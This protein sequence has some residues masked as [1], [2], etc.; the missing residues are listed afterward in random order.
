MNTDPKLL[1]ICHGNVGRSQ[2]A[3]GFYNQMTDSNDASSAGID[4]ST[5]AL[6]KRLHPN[7]IQVMREER[8]DLSSKSAKYITEE[9]IKS[10][11]KVIV[12]CKKEDCPDF[13]FKHPSVTLW[14][15]EDPF[16]L[17][18]ERLRE[19]RDDIR[20]KVYG[21]MRVCY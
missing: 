11:D 17:S 2:M 16:N 5:P 9:M 15:I 12:M 14:E 4:P 19:I 1:F 8:I 10:A 20:T 18:I 21:L 6:W 7:V 13:V 3:E